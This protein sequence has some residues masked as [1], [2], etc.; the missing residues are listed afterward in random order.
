[1]IISDDKNLNKLENIKN[2]V[3]KYWSNLDNQFQSALC[4]IE[5]Y[6]KLKV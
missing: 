1:V 5:N 6:A 3:K 4:L 2:N